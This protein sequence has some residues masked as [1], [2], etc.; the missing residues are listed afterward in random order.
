MDTFSAQ[1]CIRFGW[2]TFKKRP[3]FLI[4]AYVLIYVIDWIPSL[5]ADHTQ[6]ALSIVLNAVSWIVTVFTL[7][8]M[9]SLMLRAHDEIERVSLNDL[10]RPEKFSN[11]LFVTILQA[12]AFIVGSILLIV[13][14]IIFAI[15]F[16]FAIYLVVDTNMGPMEAMKE[17]K[18]ITHGHKWELFLLG[19]LSALVVLLGLICLIVGVLAAMPV[20]SL[21]LVHAYRVLQ[22]QAGD[23][24]KPAAA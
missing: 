7:L 14:G 10:W 5:A 1:A 4:G 12:L 11:Y 8:G 20:V 22:K 19:I 16:G 15:M 21:A 13:P 17:S 6:G 24:L 2:E 18:R 3:W 23:A 9:T